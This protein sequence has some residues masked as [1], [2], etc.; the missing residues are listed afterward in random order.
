MQYAHKVDKILLRFADCQ[1]KSNE[2]INEALYFAYCSLPKYSKEEQILSVNRSPSVDFEYLDDEG[3]EFELANNLSKLFR[4]MIAISKREKIKVIGKAKT[5]Y[6]FTFIGVEADSL[7][8]S[9]IF[10]SIYKALTMRRNQH[11]Y[12][13]CISGQSRKIKVSKSSIIR[14]TNAVHVNSYYKQIVDDISSF[15][16]P[17]FRNEFKDIISNSL[18]NEVHSSSLIH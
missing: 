7:V 16:E 4:C 17:I 1:N 10:N 12:G 8:A 6:S 2:E 18:A 5:I 9:K 3:W 14:S 15:A 13:A 11:I